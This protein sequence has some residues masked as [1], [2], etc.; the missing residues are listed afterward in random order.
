MKSHGINL[1]A[2]TIQNEP[3]HGGN[4]PSMVMT[5]A[6]QALFIKDHLGPAL[7]AAESNEWY[8]MTG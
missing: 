4:N 7:Q 3:L 1:D 8:Q 2:I 6:Q 5:A